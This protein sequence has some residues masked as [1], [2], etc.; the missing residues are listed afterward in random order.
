MTDDQKHGDALQFIFSLFLGLLLVV[1]IGVGIWTFYPQPNAGPSVDEEIQQLY[2][3]QERIHQRSGAQ[4]PSGADEA[5]LDRLQARI[6]ELAAGRNASYDVWARNTSVILLGF[7]T[8]L[9]AISLFLPERM[10]VFS[11]G[12]LLGG[13]FTVVYGTGWSFAG[14]DSR[15]RFFVVAVALVLSLGIGYLRFIRG[16]RAAEVPTLGSPS[17]PGP[18]PAAGDSAYAELDARV[19]ALERRADAAAA[20]LGGERR[21]DQADSGA[22]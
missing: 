2:R 22:A 6:D 4:P 16:A 13:L 19:T 18:G 21:L 3:Q 5:E 8:L 11:N 12:I 14:G 9:M 15:A 1:F 20:A 17:G 7:A 10:K